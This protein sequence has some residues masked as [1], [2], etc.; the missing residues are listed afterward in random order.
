MKAI[1]DNNLFPMS[2]P[3][4]QNIHNNLPQMNLMTKLITKTFKRDSLTLIC[5]GCS[6]AIIAPHIAISIGDRCGIMYVRKNSENS[7]GSKLDSFNL[8]VNKKRKLIIVDDFIYTGDTVN[9]IYKE[10]TAFQNRN[11]PSIV[12]SKINVDMLCVTGSVN[13][14]DLIFKP[15]YIISSSIFLR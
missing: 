7:H 8:L 1:T 4:A 14:K 15:N 10:L 6:G 5:K 2:Y 11:L 13:I 3:I 9:S 12:R